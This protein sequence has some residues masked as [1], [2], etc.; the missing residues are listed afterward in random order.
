MVDRLT[1]SGMRVGD[2]V[3][4]GGQPATVSFIT[5]RGGLMAL[6]G[7]THGP[8]SVTVLALSRHGNQTAAEPG[9]A[10]NPDGTRHECPL[11]EPCDCGMYYGGKQ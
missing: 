11:F 9:V 7:F 10:Y 4:L 5:P 1:A 6:V 2:R 8:D 3:T